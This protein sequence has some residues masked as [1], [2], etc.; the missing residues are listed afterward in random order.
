MA[1]CGTWSGRRQKPDALSK[2]SKLSCFSERST[3][4]LPVSDGQFGAP[5]AGYLSGCHHPLCVRH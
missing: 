4:R 1:T 3:A 2:F 5:A